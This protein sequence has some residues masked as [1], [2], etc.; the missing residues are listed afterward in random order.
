MR[1]TVRVKRL[2]A[3][4]I[5]SVLLLTACGGAQLDP[6][7]PGDRIL[8]FGDSL[9]VGVGA[10]NSNAYPAVLQQL[11]DIEVINAG[12]SGETSAQGRQRLPGVL[13]QFQPDL[14][15]LCHG[16]NDF[17][18]RQDTNGTKA[19]LAAMIELMQSRGIQV[20]LIGVPEPGLFLSSA[21][22]YE[23]LATQYDVP[24]E[25][26]IMADLQGNAS[27]KSD[28]VHLNG[29]GYRQFAQAVS[30]LL[31]DTGALP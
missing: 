23:E 27:L 15:I 26:N 19:N 29:E 31:Y 3:L 1:N 18:R 2:A 20:V 12:A 25:N 17:L 28:Q 24:V 22:L 7:G 30:A 4:L 21:R 13:D 9:T 16:G 11:T 8:A 5:A 14:V 10:S 6:I